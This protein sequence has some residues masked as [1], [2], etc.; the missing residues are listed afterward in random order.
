M[1]GGKQTGEVMKGNRGDTRQKDTVE[2][3][4]LVF[5]EFSRKDQSVLVSFSL[6]NWI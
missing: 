1:R 4:D 5:V 6:F 3:N 2:Y